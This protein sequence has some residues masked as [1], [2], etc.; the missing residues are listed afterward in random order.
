MIALYVVLIAWFVEL[1]C[2]N[3]DIW[4]RRAVRALRR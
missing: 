1:E 4:T 3:G 2:F